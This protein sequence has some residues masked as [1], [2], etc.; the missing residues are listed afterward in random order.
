IFSHY[1]VDIHS[2]SVTGVKK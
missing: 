1:K 2:H